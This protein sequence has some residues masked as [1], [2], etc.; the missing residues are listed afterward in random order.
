MLIA[1]LLAV[2]L[3]ASADTGA[4]SLVVLPEAVL[5]EA[6]PGGEQRLNFDFI[7]SN[8]GDRPLRIDGVEVSAFDAAGR[9]VLRRFVDDNG[10]SPSVE[11]LGRR[12]VPAGGRAIV[13][14]PFHT[15]PADVELG[16]LRYRVVLRDS[17][18]AEQVVDAI[19][20]PRAFRPA[21]AL[22]LP[23]AGP[24]IVYDG[25]DFYGHHRRLALSDDF[26]RQLGITSNFMRYSFDFIPVDSAGDMSRGDVA[27]NTAW[28][29][30]GAPVMAPAAGRVVAAVDT[31]ADDRTVVVPAVMQDP[32][33]L[34][35]N[36]VVIDHGG[37][38]FSLLGHIRQGSLQVRP[39]DSVT[40][41]QVVAAVGAAGSS[42]MP[43]LHYELRTGPGARGVEGLPAYFRGY[44]RHVGARRTRVEVGAPDTGEI[45]ER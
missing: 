43:H 42:H 33:A 44:T 8:D 35:G 39:G 3:A 5:I 7:L 37:G 4:V 23:L 27:E 6:G 29:G 40:S 45:V 9:L 20:R 1:P 10:S 13:F 32:V 18:N 15:F 12:D 22:S 19:V 16:E 30:F 11:T 31:A 25:H 24:I 34:Y 41:G 14:N 17:A 21:T 28:F 26:A 2:A 36:Y 38:E